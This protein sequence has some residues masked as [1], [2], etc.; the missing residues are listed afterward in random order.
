MVMEMTLL[1]ETLTTRAAQ[2]SSA[3]MQLLLWTSS[4]GSAKSFGKQV[5]NNFKISFTLGSL[6]H[7]EN[8][9]TISSN[10]LV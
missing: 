4:L 5:H 8:F 6:F 7:S 2:T 10:E 1:Q 9:V 3:Y